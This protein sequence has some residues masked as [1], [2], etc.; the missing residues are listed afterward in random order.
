MVQKDIHI[1]IYIF[2]CVC[3]IW[4]LLY[5]CRFCNQL[6]LL[7]LPIILDDGGMVKERLGYEE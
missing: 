6:L 7:L 4:D 2:V 5:N 3:F 1:Y